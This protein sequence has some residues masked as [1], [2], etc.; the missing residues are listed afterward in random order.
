MLN[1]FYAGESCDKET[2]IFDRI[3]PDEETIIIVPDQ[4]SLQMERDALDFQC[5]SVKA[6]RFDTFK[7]EN[8][9][10]KLKIFQH[11]SCRTP[12]GLQLL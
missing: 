4:A 5:F 8:F 1:I 11:E 2:F 10:Y 6:H 9:K 12:E 3:D 7:L